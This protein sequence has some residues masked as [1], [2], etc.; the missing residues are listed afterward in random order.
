MLLGTGVNTV[1]CWALSAVSRSATTSLPKAT[2][3]QHQA[4]TIVC[5]ELNATPLQKCR[6]CS[7]NNYNK[8]QIINKVPKKALKKQKVQSE[9]RQPH[10]SSLVPCSF[11]CSACNAILF[12]LKYIQK[13]FILVFL[14]IFFIFAKLFSFAILHFCRLTSYAQMS[15]ERLSSQSSMQNS[16]KKAAFSI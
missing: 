10:R 11:V 12:L 5:H 9:N 16:T 2:A 8:K 3:M 4:K 6:H 15:F 1:A 7:S 13:V 14:I